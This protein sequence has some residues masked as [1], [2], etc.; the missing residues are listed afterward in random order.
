MSV[1]NVDSNHVSMAAA[2]AAK[3]AT[4]INTEVA[5]MMAFLQGLNDTWGGLAAAGFQGLIE[6][7]RATQIQVEESLTAISNQ[8]QQASS[9]YAEAES[10]AASLFAG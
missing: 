6:Q 2:T 9:T 7:W 4:A 8:L 10:A 1:F 3:S 5:E